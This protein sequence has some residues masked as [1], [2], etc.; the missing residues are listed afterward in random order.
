MSSNSSTLS[1]HP[2]ELKIYIHTK[3]WRWG[4]S[5]GSVVKNLPA[6]AGDPGS[7]PDSGRS[8]M[9]IREEQLSLSVHR[10]YWACVLEPGNLCSFDLH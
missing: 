7:I 8:H 3:T 2:G 9:H 5:G 1:L 4:F 10:H 6:N